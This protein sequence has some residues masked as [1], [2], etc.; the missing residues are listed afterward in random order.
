MPASAPPPARCPPCAAAARRA[1]G[2]RG[3][4]ALP[5]GQGAGPR[6]AGRPRPGASS[7]PRPIRWATRPAT[8]TAGA[9]A[10][11]AMF[12]A[13]PPMCGCCT[14]CPDPQY[15][16]RGRGHRRRHLVRALEPLAGLEAM[17]QR[18][19]AR[20]RSTGTRSRAPGRGHGDRAGWTAPTCAR[21]RG[22]GWQTVPLRP[23]IPA[24][25]AWHAASA[26]R[27]QPICR[28][29]S[30]WRTTL[31]SAARG[32]HCGKRRAR[33]ELSGETARQAPYRAPRRPHGSMARSK[34]S[35]PA[36]SRPS[37]SAGR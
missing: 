8:P 22:S 12:T 3:R 23:A 36:D 35:E 37:F 27:A 32:R 20:A 24:P 15:L 31:M 16:G 7:R 17:R 5:A 28:C 1:T 13:G 4:L 2:R 29:A 25:S 26:C 19:P 11:G 21:A 6:P 18:R 10:N 34:S 30:S 33:P 9:H 14:A